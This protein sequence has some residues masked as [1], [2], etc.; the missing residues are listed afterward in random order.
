MPK[1]KTK[2][3]S[4]Q[5]PKIKSI[6]TKLKKYHLG[7]L[8]KYQIKIVVLL[9]FVLRH[10]QFVTFFIPFL[11]WAFIKKLLSRLLF[12]FMFRFFWES[13]KVDTLCKDKINALDDV[14]CTVSLIFIALKFIFSQTR[15]LCILCVCFMLL[16]QL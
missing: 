3:A 9:N 10:S 4:N 14:L 15:I 1:T 16:P 2:N 13:S 7:L 11:T 5:K 12:V 8:R 6:K